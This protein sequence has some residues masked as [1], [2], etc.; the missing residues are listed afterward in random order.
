MTWKA[1]TDEIARRR[2]LALN[3][4]GTEAIAKQHSQ[5]RLTIRERIEKLID[6]GSLEEVGPAAGTLHYDD[7]GVLTGLDPANF[8]L[9]FAKVEGRRIIVGGEDFPCA[10]AH[11][12]RRVLGKASMR[13]S[14]RCNTGCP[15]SVYT[16]VRVGVWVARAVP[17]P[18]CQGRLMRQRV[19]ALSPRLWRLCRW[20]ARL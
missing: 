8:V 3:Q 12:R 10:V 20:P 11:P 6:P 9:G 19:F 2:T 18:A 7:N 15:W 1:E 17:G 13:K 16:R 4:G 14:W 5:N